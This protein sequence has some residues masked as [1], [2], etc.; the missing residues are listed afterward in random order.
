MANIHFE[1]DAVDTLM[2]RDGRPFNQNDAGASEAT[3]VFPPPPPTL[4][5]AIRAMFWQAL[6]GTKDDWNKT[7]LG[8]GTDWQHPGTLGPLRFGAVQLMLDKAPVFPVPLHLVEGEDATGNKALT[9]LDPRGAFDCDLGPGIQL[10]SARNTKL[11]GIKTISDRWLT[12]EGMQSIL[13]GNVPTLD[14]LITRTKLWSTEP[15]VGIGI[16]PQSRITT[17]GRLYMASHVRM[18]HGATLHIEVKGWN[19]A[20]DFAQLRPVAG[21]HRMAFVS[22]LSPG[23]ELS[24]P[25]LAVG[26]EGRF[27]VIALSP[28]VP[29]RTDDGQSRICGMSDRDIVS[30]C[31]GKPVPIGGWSSKTTSPVPLRSCIPAGSV[32]FMKAGAAIPDAIGQAREWGFGQ[33]LIGKW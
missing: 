14:Q 33:V 5:G 1:I 4:V 10:P 22:A 9:F 16:D 31:L 6:G 28:V 21:E 19:D 27:C 30:A 12:L 15:H 3:S 25:T 32:W 2:F 20:V 17:D 8:D 13:H 18:T 24:L 29:T 7:K 11:D 26:T 23:T